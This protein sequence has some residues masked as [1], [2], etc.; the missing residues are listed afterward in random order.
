[1]KNLC[2]ILLA[3]LCLILLVGVAPGDGLGGHGGA[4]PVDELRIVRF[5]GAGRPTMVS[6]VPIDEGWT[7]EGRYQV[8]LVDDDQHTGSPGVGIFPPRETTPPKTIYLHV[9]GGAD[10]PWGRF[11]WE[12]DE[13]PR[14]E[15]DGTPPPGPQI[16]LGPLL[17]DCGN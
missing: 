16:D 1:M 12:L 4:W 17:G 11:T 10:D 8:T 7:S 14:V 2:L 15:F 3:A 13:W 5:D 6:L 9:R